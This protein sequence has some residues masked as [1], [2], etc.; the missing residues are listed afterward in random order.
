MDRTTQIYPSNYDA[1]IEQITELV[2]QSKQKALRTV[3]STLVEMNWNIGKYIVE[4]EQNGN[5]RAEYGVKLLPQLSRDLTLR[6]GNGY[7]KSNLANMRLLYLRF[8][9]F[10]AV[11]GKLNWTQLLEIITIED[12]LERNFYAVETI[13]QNWSYRQIHEQ[14]TR[15][16]FYQLATA[17]DAPDIL[18]L[19]NNGLQ[20]TQPKDIIKDTYFFDFL[21]LKAPDYSEG[22]LEDAL[23][24]HMEDFLLELGKGFAFVGRQYRLTI[25]NDDYYADLVFYHV[26]LKCYVI[27]DLKRGKV[28]HDDIGQMNMYLGYFAMDKNTD[29]DNPPI[30]IILAAD[31]NDVM[32]QYATYGMDANLFVAKYQLYLPEINELKSLVQAEL[33]RLNDR[34]TQ[35]YR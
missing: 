27:I 23:I 22:T 28:K 33:D 17:K 19:S 15:G 29:G 25:D 32:V 5:A 24:K 20:I 30:G 34:T 3:N 26:I 7:S 35:T 9:I 2:A 16:L 1:L 18:S 10:Q 13:N 31:K 21:S 8:P 4:F 11:L 14:K 6:F 12:E